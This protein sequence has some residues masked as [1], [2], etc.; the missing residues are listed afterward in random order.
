MREGEEEWLELCRQASVEQDREKLFKLVQRINELL[1]AKDKRLRRVGVRDV[2]I[3][4][5]AYDSALLIGRSELLR[6]RGY[7]VSSA[8]G[9]EDAK[10]IL[11]QARGY[12]LFIVGH[13]APTETRQ[14]MVQWVKKNFPQAK[15]L[16]LNRPQ[17]TLGDADFN[18]ILNGPEKWLATVET[19]FG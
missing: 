14:E 8:L 4:Q 9:N 18:F 1:E 2:Q 12:R 13:A 6:S 7:E 16:A 19:I 17:N 3:F 11:D 15:V 5:I 10:R